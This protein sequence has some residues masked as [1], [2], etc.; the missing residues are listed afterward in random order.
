MTVSFW[1]ILI[2]ALAY[3]LLHSFLASLKMKV[4]AHHWLGE[5]ADRWF[6]LAYNFIA[7]ITLIP[8][9]FL[10]ILKPDQ[11]IYLIPFPWIFFTLFIQGLA[12]VMLLIG[13]WQTGVTSFLGLRQIFRAEDTSPSKLVIHGL[14]RYVRHP[15]YTAGLIFIWLTPYLS[16]NWLAVNL[17]FTIYIFIG[18]YFEERKLLLE[19][20]EAYAEYQHRTPMLIPG[21]QLSHR[22]KK[23]V[24]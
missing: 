6:R 13:L 3:G 5:L 20:G 15:L 22:L 23:Q 10:T 8:I 9:L 19:F 2:T 18:A 14:Y 12:L 21:L 1:L 11:R 4:Y 7:I 17:S 24:H 16:W